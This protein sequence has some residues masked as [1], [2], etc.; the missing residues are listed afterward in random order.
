MAP[1][2]I[3]EA[4]GSDESGSGTQNAPYKTIAY[5]LFKHSDDA[6]V[7]VRKNGEAPYD[8]PSD[9]A[10]KKAKKGAEGLRKKAEKE[11]E[12]AE[13]EAKKRA[14]VEHKL[15]ESKKIVLKEDVTLPKAVKVC[16]LLIPAYQATHNL[17][18]GKAKL[19][20][21]ATLRGQRIGVSGWVHRLRV[22]KGMMFIVLR[23][24]TGYL[25]A[26]ITGLGVSLIFAMQR[27]FHSPI[28]V[29]I[30]R[31]RRMKPLP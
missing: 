8:R 27:G 25:Q 22:Q 14:E 11:A 9:S 16:Y 2:Y 21:L 5:A 10:L 28:N 18:Y 4:T 31:L 19:N 12:N 7:Q 24:G 20:K 26:V 30:L 23:D 15:E 3:D 29:H 13:R 1:V 17:F 6:E